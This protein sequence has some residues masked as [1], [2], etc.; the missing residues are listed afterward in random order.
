MR[1]VSARPIILGLNISIEDSAFLRTE[2]VYE[3]VGLN[4]GNL[5]FHYAIDWQLGSRL[6]TLPWQTAPEVLNALQATGILPL[7]NQL[8]DHCD[9]SDLVN[10]FGRIAC[11]LVA[12]GLGAQAGPTQSASEVTVPPGTLDWL[13]IILT[14]APADAP[15]VALRGEFT[16]QVLEHYGLA[17]GTIVIGCPTL[18]ISAEPRLGKSIAERFQNGVD[19]IAVAAGLPYWPHLGRL[20]ASLVHLARATGGAY[21]CQSEREMVQIGRGEAHL[22]DPDVRDLCR[23]YIA[24][25]MSDREF[26]NWTR[27]YALS[28]FS[29]A[30]WIEHIRRYDFVIGAR[31]HGVVLALQAGVPALCIA[32]D[33]RT[34]ELCEIMRV[35]FVQ[36]KDVIDGIER[37]DIPRLFQFDPDEFDR[38]RLMLANRYVEFLQGNGLQPAEYLLAL[39]RSHPQMQS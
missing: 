14:R 32:H 25:D 6:R 28:F 11:P 2:D 4:T 9:L 15:N 12:I 29:V 33:S 3:Q 21:I 30:A 23:R 26:I 31:I 22:L 18:F 5:A 20:E 34:A 27:R 17:D 36:A 10:D 35:P 38:N 24:P 8:G 1:K 13:R 7:A 19:L 37:D 39:G 16:R